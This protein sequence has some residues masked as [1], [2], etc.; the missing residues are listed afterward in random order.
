MVT[1]DKLEE[2]AHLSWAAYHASCKPASEAIDNTASLSSLLP[3]FYEDSK[4]VAMICHGMDMVK[5]AVDI[6]NPGQVPVITA[7]QPLYAIAKEI[8]WAWPECY[9]EER[10]VVLFGGLLIEMAALK[11]LGDLLDGSEWIGALIPGQ[12]LPWLA[13]QIHI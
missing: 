2:D 7:D 6:C 13:Q 12:R 9:G 4:S 3:L 10:F 8:Q 5:D 11:V 1:K